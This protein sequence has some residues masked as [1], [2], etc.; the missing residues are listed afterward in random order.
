M[1]DTDTPPPDSPTDPPAIQSSQLSDGQEELATA[2]DLKQNATNLYLREV[3]PHLINHAGK[4]DGKY[5]A[6]ISLS[7]HIINAT[8]IG[9]GAYAYDT[10][11]RSSSGYDDD[12]IRVLMAALTLHDSNKFVDNHY[13]QDADDNTRDVLER[14]FEDDLFNVESILPGAVGEYF[15]D[16]LYLVQRTETGEDAR[17][18]R[19][20]ETEYA[21]LEAYC[22]LGDAVASAIS[23]EGISAG[24]DRLRRHYILEEES[25]VQT[26]DITPIEQPLLHNE[27]LQTTKQI[28]KA[29]EE[30]AGFVLGSTDGSILYLGEQVDRDELADAVQNA[31][32]ERI[33]DNYDFGCKTRWNSVEYQSL[34]DIDLDF[35]TKRE[36]LA[37]Q[38]AE[39][40]LLTGS[41]LTDD[42]GLESVPDEV[43][44]YLPELLKRVYIDDGESF[45]TETVQRIWDAVEEP[46]KRKRHT[47]REL[48]RNFHEHE[49]AI[50]AEVETARE[51]LD[52]DLTPEASVLGT[53]VD[54]AFTSPLAH[55]SEETDENA[56]GSDPE[57]P[58]ATETCFL[59]GHA[60]TDRYSPGD[61]ALYQS[62][63]FS[64]RVGFAQNEKQICS[65]CQLEYSLFEDQCD[66][67]DVNTGD[68]VLTAYFY[69][70]DFH[71]DVH[72]HSS[73]SGSLIDGETV[74]F[75]DPDIVAGLFGPQYHIQPFSTSSPGFSDTDAKLHT[76]RAILERLRETG[77]RATI[78]QPLTRAHPDN[79]VFHDTEPVTEQLILGCAQIDS[80]AELERP[81]AL[82]RLLASL[83]GLSDR[84]NEDRYTMLDDDSLV[85]LVHEAVRRLD[86]PGNF[87]PLVDYAETYHTTE[88]NAMK[89]V[90]KAGLDLYGEQ[91]NS[92]HMKT[93]VFR[94]ALDAALNGLNNDMEEDELEQFVASRVYARAKRQRYAGNVTHDQAA[95]FADAVFTY[96]TDRDLCSL[97]DLADWQDA[98]VDLYLFAYE[99]ERDRDGDDEDDADAEAAAD[100][101][102]AADTPSTDN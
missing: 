44:A 56:G 50:L 99:S 48:V 35:D 7:T 20:T 40:I 74:D 25:P 42:E 98:L 65:L 3:G 96:L 12:E 38:F 27:L 71:P 70:D 16:L 45:Q 67:F 17:E 13:A 37:T 62:R 8:L 57:I 94:T 68:T 51:D 64:K 24:A 101:E 49:Q 54:R 43:M 2:R 29:G 72:L 82:L 66:T 87:E 39:N 92:K 73:L 63:G 22:E 89:E 14:Y 85:S 76:I 46:Q 4:Y 32:G 47:I 31:L 78:G 34:A 86:S 102:P 15:D 77:M 88:L 28:L 100:G 36:I 61:H 55:N 59:C 5:N 95:A 10:I 91:Y 60:A 26:L 41:G 19:G 18:S 80:Y 6:A 81:S 53:A 23:G 58:S 9:V 83:A 93:S 52:A 30:P 75:D 79:A 97:E 1:R 33:L 21:G 90:A 11:V 84:N 69:F